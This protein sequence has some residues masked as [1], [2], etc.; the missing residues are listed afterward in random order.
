MNDNKTVLDLEKVVSDWAWRQYDN[1]ATKKEKK[2]RKKDKKARFGKKG[3]YI[4][5]QVDWSEMHSS[6]STTWDA[7]QNH[8]STHS[9]GN[10]VREAEGAASGSVLFETKF[11]NTTDKEM[12]YTMSTQKTTTTTCSTEI[13]SSFTRGIDVGLTLK[14]PGEFVEANVGY[15]REYS[16][17]NIS[18]ETFEHEMSWGVDSQITVD[19]KSIVY[20]ALTVDEREKKG[21]FTITTEL[22][23]MVYVTF[24]EIRNNNALLKATGYPITDIVREWLS[25]Q[26]NNGV[27]VDFVKVEDGKVI[28]TT[29]GVCKFRYGVKQEV[30]VRQ[31]SLNNAK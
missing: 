14:A 24:T 29:K 16:L 13:E 8:E 17:T 1:T 10:Q 19:K 9:Q 23:G 28:I 20:A 15:S 27:I 21:G 26:S 4:N 25:R 22:Q 5:V 30:K 31:E 12:Q 11:T 2:L 6:D 18:G 3:I 7:I